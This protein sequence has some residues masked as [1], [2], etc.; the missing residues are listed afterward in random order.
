MPVPKS[1]TAT[2]ELHVA[3]CFTRNIKRVYVPDM[4]APS[5]VPINNEDCAYKSELFETCRSSRAGGGWD[6]LLLAILKRP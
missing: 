2:K 1:T 3:A 5:G 4:L 6:Q